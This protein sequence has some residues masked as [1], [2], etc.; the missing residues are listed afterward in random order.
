MNKMNVSQSMDGN[1][2]TETVRRHIT[3][4]L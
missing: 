2:W 4:W 3:E 1:G